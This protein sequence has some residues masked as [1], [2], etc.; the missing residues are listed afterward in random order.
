MI[1]SP[2][3]ENED[4]KRMICDRGIAAPAPTTEHPDTIPLK[5]AA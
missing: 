5:R 1:D 4:L 3:A 2:Y